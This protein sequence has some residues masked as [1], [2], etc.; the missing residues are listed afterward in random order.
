MNG[1]YAQ[2]L[3]VSDGF[4]LRQSKEFPLI[5]QAR[6]GINGKVTMVHLVD[7]KVSRGF[8]DRSFVILPSYGIRV[9]QVDDGSTLPVDADRLRKDSRCLL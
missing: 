4:R 8:N 9:F 3:E 5:S 6:R 1:I 2:F 7:H